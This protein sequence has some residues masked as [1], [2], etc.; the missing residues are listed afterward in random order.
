[1]NWKL[2]NQ[3]NQ[4]YFYMHFMEVEDLKNNEIR[5]FDIIVDGN[6]WY[7]NH[8]VP[9]YLSP[10]TIASTSPSKEINISLEK[11][12]RSTLPP[13]INAIEV[14]ELIEFLQSDTFQDD[15]IPNFLNAV[16][17]FILYTHTHRIKTNFYFFCFHFKKN[18]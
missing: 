17:L 9:S 13:I 15:G 5:E 8:V 11:T 7:R 2:Q 6:R 3:N 12:Q 16:L 1:M 4:Y 10:N 14:Y 18:S